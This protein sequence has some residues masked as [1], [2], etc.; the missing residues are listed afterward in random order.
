MPKN[1]E[2][3]TKLW[4]REHA[5]RSGLYASGIR[6][7]NAKLSDAQVI[8]IHRLRKTGISRGELAKQFNISRS[9][10]NNMLIGRDRKIVFKQLAARPKDE[11]SPQGVRDEQIT[12]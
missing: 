5:R 7:P 6:H 2:W 11:G 9:S 10:V 8:E 1:L 12:T 3:C 4:N